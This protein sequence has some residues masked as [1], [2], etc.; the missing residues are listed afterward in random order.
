M[1][2]F[3]ASPNS[4]EGRYALRLTVESSG[5]VPLA[6]R[7]LLVTTAGESSRVES[8]SGELLWLESP[9]V[10]AFRRLSQDGVSISRLEIIRRGTDNEPALLPVDFG[11]EGLAMRGIDHVRD[12]LNA[13]EITEVEPGRY[14]LELEDG[15]RAEARLDRKTGVILSVQGEWPTGFH[16]SVNVTSILKHPYDPD[17][18]I[19]E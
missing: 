13:D 14:N 6:P 17:E 2:G 7:C 8:P 15:R 5:A 10:L 1:R 19:I 16:F 9:R 18:F 12:W 11:E 4:F 3:V